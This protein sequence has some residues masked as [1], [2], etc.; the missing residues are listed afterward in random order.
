MCHH[1][2]MRRH[3]TLSR[4]HYTGTHVWSRNV[5]F[6]ILIGGQIIRSQRLYKGIK[7]MTEGAA[8][9]PEWLYLLPEDS[10][11][12]YDMQCRGGQKRKEPPG[13]TKR[14]CPKQQPHWQSWSEP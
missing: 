5:L 14:K 7:K 2:D 8:R 4:T 12:R 1:I 6:V 9:S 10:R 3:A 13:R 11:E